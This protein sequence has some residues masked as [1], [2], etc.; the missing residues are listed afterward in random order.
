MRYTFMI[1]AEPG[2]KF[3]HQAARTLVGQQPRLN[4]RDYEDGPVKRELGAGRVV[5]AIVT[6]DGSG[7]YVTVETGS[8]PVWQAN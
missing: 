3:T 4:L 1:P 6:K 2:T 5:A 8:E 7:V